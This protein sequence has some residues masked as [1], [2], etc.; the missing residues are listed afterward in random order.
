MP[1]WP[2]V[3]KLQEDNTNGQCSGVYYF[4]VVTV[5]FMSSTGFIA[6]YKIQGLFKDLKLQF[7]GTKSIDEK[8]Y[9]THTTSKFRA[10]YIL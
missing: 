5:L 2:K 3:H 10:K 4:I 1:Q 9:Y 6:N 7:S 8:T